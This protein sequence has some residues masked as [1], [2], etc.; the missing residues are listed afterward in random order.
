M[1]NCNIFAKHCITEVVDF[2]R[3]GNLLAYPS[4]SVWG[5]GCDGM[6]VPALERLLVLKNRPSHKGLIVL[7][8]D[9]NK[10]RPLLAKLPNIDQ[11]DILQK[12]HRHTIPNQ[13]T[14]WL[15]PVSPS[16][17]LPQILMGDFDKLA[18]RL[19]HHP[20]LRQICHALTSEQNPYGFLVSTS[21]NPS[22]K[23]PASSL[24]MAKAYF[25][26]QVG[27][28]DDVGLGYDKPSQIIDVLTGVVVR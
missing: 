12:I 4:E 10:I 9:I 13:A 26:E 22:T 6:C 5:V 27:Y 8:D 18:V 1:P 23:P 25:G 11:D 21:C 16:V 7:T 15:V 24:A 14:T 20:Q 19:T 17:D 2:L 28:F 3:S